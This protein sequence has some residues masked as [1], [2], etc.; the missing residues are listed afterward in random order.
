[1]PGMSIGPNYNSTVIHILGRIS[2][3]G[4]ID[5]TKL[6]QLVIL[7]PSYLVLDSTTYPTT[8]EGVAEW[9]QG[10]NRICDVVIALH[11]K[12]ALDLET[13][14]EVSRSCAESWVICGS[15]RGL[16]SGRT[17]IQRVA[18]RL[19]ENV[20][21]ADGVRYKGETVYTS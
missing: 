6:R 20:L 12:S 18:G 3:S 13:L 11:R 8:A 2:A 21:D 5:Q 1:M 7:A 9:S 14:N 17:A 4:T 16:D 15:W 10:M 19:K